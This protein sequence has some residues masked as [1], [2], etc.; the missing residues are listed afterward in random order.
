MSLRIESHLP[1]DLEELIHNVIG[2][3]LEVHSR[4]G[5]GFLESIYERALCHEFDLRHI[6]YECQ[7]EIVVPYKGITIPGQ[8]VDI[9]VDGRLV[10]ELKAADAISPIHEAQLLSSLKATG[11]RAGLLVNF[12]VTQLRN[13]IKRM[14]L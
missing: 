5:P 9:L 3:A 4:L 14:V 1:T 10:I 12:R 6:A 8:R 7:K 2:A 11:C 13:G